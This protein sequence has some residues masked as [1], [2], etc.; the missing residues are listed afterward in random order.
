MK[1]RPGVKLREGIAVLGRWHI[2]EAGVYGSEQLRARAS[3]GLANAINSVRMGWRGERR[4]GIQIRN[5]RAR[6]TLLT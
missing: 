2:Y 6:A 5:P 3:Q 4:V 1:A